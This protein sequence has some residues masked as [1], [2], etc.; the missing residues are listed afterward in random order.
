MKSFFPGAES[1]TTTTMTNNKVLLID[2]DRCCVCGRCQYA[3]SFSKEGSFNLALSRISMVRMSDNVVSSPMVCQHCELP[4]CTL[5]CPVNAITKDKDTG[6]VSIDP[7]ICVGCLQCFLACPLGGISIS[8][9]HLPFKCDLCGGDPQCVLA[10][11]YD[12]IMYVE[13]EQAISM[14]KNKGLSELVIINKS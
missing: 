4:F 12:A 13:V 6:I 7:E 14:K 8:P 10:C 2:P 3:C 9:E 11:E 5:A 1:K